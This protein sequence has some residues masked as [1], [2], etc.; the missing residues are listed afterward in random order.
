VTFKKLQALLEKDGETLSEEVWNVIRLSMGGNPRKTKRFA[1][2]FYLSG[3]FLNHPNQD[4]QEKVQNGSLSR[5]SQ[6]RQSFYLAKILAFQM[7][8]PD[9]YQHL[10]H[11]P[12]DWR[13]LEEEVILQKDATKREQTLKGTVKLSEF[14]A[15]ASFRDFMSKT[16]K[17]TSQN[18]PPAPSYDIVEALLDATSLVTET[19]S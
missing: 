1:N 19:P 18:N 2:S 6:E 8:F 16:S 9:F 12:G 7:S 17:S 15:D 3:C 14:W 10:R 13:Y 4:L 5:I 11:H